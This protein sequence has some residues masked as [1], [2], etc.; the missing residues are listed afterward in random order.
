MEDFDTGGFI[1]QFTWRNRDVTIRAS[2]KDYAAMW[3]KR[4]P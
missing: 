3:L 4:H 2:G 1:V